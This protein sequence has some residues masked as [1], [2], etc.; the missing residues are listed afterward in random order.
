MSS[1]KVLKWV[2]GGL[3]AILG[4]PFL[5]GTIVLS[6]AWTPL[7]IM[8]VL[9]IITLILAKKEGRSVAGSILGIVTSCIAWIPLV[10]MIMHIITAIVLMVDAAKSYRQA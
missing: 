9:H 7:G 3:E 6:L 8:L 4:V 5:G 10:G 1:S 2:T